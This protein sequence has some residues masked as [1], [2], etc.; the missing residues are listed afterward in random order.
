MDISISSEGS[1]PGVRQ[2]MSGA[3]AGHDSMRD[4]GGRQLRRRAPVVQE[5]TAPN[6]NTY[7]NSQPNRGAED[8]R[9]AEDYEAP[10]PQGSPAVRRRAAR[11]RE[12]TRRLKWTVEMNI[13]V[14]RTFY[15]IN[16]CRDEPL[17]GWR[18][19]LHAEFLRRNPT[20][21]ITEQ[22]IVDRK[23]VIVRKR[24]L[25]DLQLQE[26]KREVGQILYQQEEFQNPPEVRAEEEIQPPQRLITPTSTPS[27]SEGRISDAHLP[28]SQHEERRERFLQLV[29][30]YELINPLNRPRIPKLRNVNKA[31]DIIS[32]ANSILQQY[33]DG[34]NDLQKAHLALYCASA[35]ILELN[36]QQVYT[37]NPN[38]RKKD[39]DTPM[40][41]KRL[42]KNIDEHRADADVL[43]EFL[44]GN[45]SRRVM[46]KTQ[47]I[48]R[49]AQ[50]DLNSA[51]HRQQLLNL[52]DLLRQKAKAKGARLRRYNKLTKRKQQN[53]AF[54]NNQK[55]DDIKMS[56]GLDKCATLSIVKGA[57]HN[58]PEVY[59]DMHQLPPEEQYRYLGVCQDGR[60]NHTQLKKEFQEKYKSRVTKLLNTLLSG[61]NLIKAIN[62]WAVPVLTYSFGIVKWSV[63]DLDELDRLTRRLLTKFR[64]LHTNSSVIRLYL[65]RRRGGRGLLNI[66]NQCLN[67]QAS[68]R[69]R[70]LT[71]RDPLITA[72]AREDA[73]YT[74]LSLG[75]THGEA[76]LVRATLFTGVANPRTLAM[77]GEQAT[78]GEAGLVTATLFTGVA[79]PRTLAMHGG[80]GL[81]KVALF[82]GVATPHTLATHGEARLVRA[83]L[84]TGVATP[85][86][87][88]MHGEQAAHGEAKLVRVIL[89]SGMATPRTPAKARRSR[90]G[91]SFPVLG[92]GKP[93]YFS[94]HRNVAHGVPNT[95][96]RAGDLHGIKFP[97]LG[98]S[99][100]W[101]LTSFWQKKKDT[102]HEIMNISIV[103]QGSLPGVRQGMSGAGAGHDS[104]RDVGGRQLRRRAPVIQEATAPNPNSNSQPNRGVDD[105]RRAEDYEAPLPQGSPAVRR[106]AARRRED[107]RRLKWTVEMNIE[108]MRTFYII[109]HCRDE[110]L[111]GWRHLLHAEFLR[112]NP[113]FNITEQNIVDRKNVIVRKRYLTDLQL[114]EV[115]REVGQILYQQEEFQIQPKERAEEEIQPPQRL[116]TP[117]SSPSRSEG[118]ISVVHL[119]GTQ[120]EE[121][122]ERFL[123]L[124]T[125]YELIN[126]L[127]RPRIP[128]LRNANKAR[129][130]ISSANSI[131]QQYLDGTNDLQKAHLGVYCASALILEL[132]GQQ[133]YTPNPNRRNKNS[134]APMWR[135]RL[136]KNIDEHRADADVLNEF[137]AGNN[138]R[139]V[140]TKTQAIARKA[141]I[142][143]NNADHRQQLL[144]LK[145]LL[146]QKA[147]AKGARLRRY[148]KLTKRKQ[149]NAA[150]ENNQ[151]QFLR[152][153]EKQDEEQPAEIDPVRF[154]TYW[155]S[156]WNGRINHTQ[157]KK[158]FQEKYKSR[159]TKLLNTLL[160]GGNLI[161]AINSWA[162]PVLTYSFGIVKWSVTD[163]DELDRL[164][165]RLLTKFR[166]LHTNSSVIRLYQPRRR[167]GRGLLN[168]KNQCLNQE[169][170]LRRKILN[171][172]DPLITAVAREDAGYT[173]L[174]LGC[175]LIPVDKT[176]REKIAKYENLS[177]ELK[178]LWKLEKVETYA[179]VI[180]AEGVM[181]TRFAKNI[182]VLGLSYNII[183]NG[184]KAVVLQTC[185]IV[186]KVLGQDEFPPLA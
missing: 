64:H 175:E 21:N 35:L 182:A 63:T 31:R 5:A 4:V 141:Q 24:Y 186:R 13:E 8:T 176:E 58:N 84:F 16:R 178:R 27:R 126:P 79:N 131:L 82:S 125:H 152:S 60:I 130:I 124:V 150:F 179:L 108:V 132:N 101:L 157:L 139:R 22:N 49:K 165:R 6:P 43:N 140:M 104:M 73:G 87:L 59:A 29:T 45:N 92:C 133:V 134:D 76:R 56:F 83:S 67:Q 172:R 106:R 14:M 185:H 41:R 181:T 137:L 17:P 117:T 153:L 36:G 170:S 77:H 96:V 12:D 52:K 138:S 107:T 19:S 20:F 95:P 156:I 118:R 18:H 65:P 38:R 110:P 99:E 2:G 177:I 91:G 98:L 28:R 161:K 105:T 69:R 168:I 71:N 119:P 120:H 75:S 145:D 78:H 149:Q 85:R 61:G 30:H 72:V 7:S 151:K 11:R 26:V 173:P 115:K 33:L 148:N 68:L 54:E 47:A 143:L 42:E 111:P 154:T 74:P 37:P 114:Q 70:L 40:W 122:Q 144:N 129:D 127:N 158:E 15:I 86:T 147:K 55:H 146:R 113:T 166:Q 32:S 51:D 44:V 34:T 80:A 97:R 94:R 169:A 112:R 46:A 62:S 89:F 81:V 159:V 9:R 66:K 90:L 136:E 123:Q 3:G 171:N 121:R 180:S 10:L 102:D 174:S 25:T 48:A 103:S 88:A 57:P 100:E 183:R 142:D 39:S 167:G 93:A 53:A 109:N 135:K 50:I 184:Q 160:S 1:L 162:V 116:I 155:N 23:N 128:K 163:L 164:T